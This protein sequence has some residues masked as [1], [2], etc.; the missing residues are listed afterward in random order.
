MRL[1]WI[2]IVGVILYVALDAIV[3]SLPPHYSPTRGAESDLVVGPYGY[4]MTIN[5]LNRGVLSLAFVYSFVKTL[6]LTGAPRRSF[7]SGCY[8]IS[9]WGVGALLLAIFPTDVPAL[10]MSGHGAIHLL[11]AIIAF[12]CGGLGTFVL[13]RHFDRNTATKGA[14]KVALGL[15]SLS[16]LLL[17]VELFAQFLVPHVAANFGGL[18]ERLFLGSVLLWIL[19]VS[20][21]M[22]THRSALLG[23]LQAIAPREENH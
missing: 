8:L 6:D 14:K 10:P 18:T 2:S 5:F 22:V 17:V 13:S 12:I 21:Y 3:Q 23:Q 1:Y 9:A 20:I 4:I 19:V 16:V 7:L 15:G 11:V